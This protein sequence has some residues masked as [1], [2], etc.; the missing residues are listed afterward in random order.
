[1]QLLLATAD[2]DADRVPDDLCD[3]VVEHVLA[4]TLGED[5]GV[6]VAEDVAG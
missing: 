5:D 6:T 4:A 2:W 3:Y 1:M